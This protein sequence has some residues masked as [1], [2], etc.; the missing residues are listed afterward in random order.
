M[1][2]FFWVS[3][4][5]EY[6]QLDENEYIEEENIEL[7]STAGQ[8]AL[9][10]LETPFEYIILAPI[11][12][13]EL[14]DVDLSFN[15]NVLT[16][17]W[18]RKRPEIYSSDIVIKNSECFWWKFIRNIILPENLDFDSI[19]ASIENNLLVITILKLKF[20]S[21]KIEIDQI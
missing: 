11:A 8:V 7:D 17:A 15:N 4:K 2:K 16:I 6:T 20:N 10:I 18:E 3:K 14:N 21:K 9:D 12:W 19:K 1:F 5:E 13:I